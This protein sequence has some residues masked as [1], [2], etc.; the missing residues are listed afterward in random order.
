MNLKRTPKKSSK[1]K[2]GKLPLDK[3]FDQNPTIK[4]PRVY[5]DLVFWL[6]QRP[7]ER[8]RTTL[9]VRLWGQNELKP[10]ELTPYP[11]DIRSR[12]H[13]YG[14]GAFAIKPLNDIFFLT[15]VSALDNCLWFQKFCI[16]RQAN[17]KETKTYLISMDS[18]IC[19]S[20][21]GEYNLG[22]GLIDL[23]RKRWLG[24]MELNN[25]DFIVTYSLEERNQ[26]PQII[27]SAIDFAGYPSI[28]PEGDHLTWVEWQHPFMP[29]DRSQLYF[30]KLA[31]NGEVLEKEVI[32]GSSKLSKSVSVFQPCW[33][34][35]DQII[36]AEDSGG[37]WN[38]I[39]SD[40]RSKVDNFYSWRKLCN[41]KAEFGQPQWVAGMSSYGISKDKVICSICKDGIWKIMI[42]NNNGNYEI[43]DQ[44][45]EEISS[46]FIDKN[47]LIAIASNP[48]NE[49]GLLELNIID[50]I[51]YHEAS[52]RPILKKDEISI[53]ESLW[54]KGFNGELTQAWY[55]SPINKYRK[56]VPLLVRVHSGPTAMSGNG[57][58]L[59][60]Q[61]WTSRGWGILDVNYG[62][63]SGYG[64]EYR[65][66]LKYS[67]GKVDVFD[68]IKAA[69][70]LIKKGIA[71]KE[72]IAIEGG[73]AG[74]FTALCCLYSSNL[75]KVAA[76][77]YAVADL[78]LMS[79]GTH[80]FEDGYLNYLIGSLDSEYDSYVDRSPIYNIHKI[81]TPIIFFQG[82]K[83]TV[84]PAE[85]AIAITS[86]LKQNDVPFEMHTY[87]TE[88][89]GFKNINV[90]SDVL[91]R[92]EKFFRRYLKLN[93]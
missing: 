73:S 46:I 65:E 18:A 64:R 87:P 29:W 35:N 23:V 10:Q 58:D 84:V 69:E 20:S 12:V 76:C 34:S 6:E 19:L 17:I 90:K 91:K 45:F 33:L 75:F 28:S 74:G 66:R 3:V 37:W 8:G 27:Y 41:I 56:K 85:Q 70:I 47:R 38:L 59:V 57:L 86:Q 32:A 53:A 83:D 49:S 9:L 15:W 13:G 60:V 42:I 4:E 61:F 1:F 71:D 89:H 25:K 31:I 11:L 44:P 16:S 40:V 48:F 55:Y 51:F 36:V 14:G 62:G 68:C 72:L 52:R 50:K 43:I 92:T 79:K 80:R 39:I 7:E 30:A 22:D 77:K 67:W 93:Y 78:V 21:K 81:D 88:G 54:F 5:G 82:L 26:S 24:I 63:S 2:I